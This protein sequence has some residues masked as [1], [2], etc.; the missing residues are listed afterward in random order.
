MIITLKAKQGELFY[1][2]A[3]EPCC[4]RMSEDLLVPNYGPRIV[5]GVTKDIANHIE[6]YI[7]KERDYIM[8]ITHCPHCGR[9]IVEIRRK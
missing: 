5:V 8:S 3:I 1:V 2:S 9:K 7:Q 4:K 6:V